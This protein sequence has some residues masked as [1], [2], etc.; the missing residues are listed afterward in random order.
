MLPPENK[1][2]SETRPSS[3]KKRPTQAEIIRNT[4][5]MALFSAL[6]YVVMLVVHIP[7]SFLTFDA[8]DAV[9]AVAGFIWGPLPAVGMSLLVAL[10]ELVTVSGTGLYGFLMNFVSSAVFCGTASLLYRRHRTIKRVYLSLFVACVALCA[11]MVLMNLWITPL[12][13]G[14]STDV[15]LSLIPTLLLPFNAAKAFLNSGIC[16]LLY[17]PVVQALRHT[18]MLQKNA[19]TPDASRPKTVRRREFLIIGSA[20]LLIGAAVTVFLLLK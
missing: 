8:K 4:V 7:I 1:T 14:V 2:Q 9:L 17:K 12:Y 19:E 6:A 10:L 20:V 15:I 11:S 3:P 5:G 16:L 13:M 18:G